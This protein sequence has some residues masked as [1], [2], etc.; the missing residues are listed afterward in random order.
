MKAR[1]ESTFENTRDESL[2]VNNVVVV[3]VKGAQECFAAFGLLF[4]EV[5]NRVE[6]DLVQM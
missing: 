1:I 3:L 6:R 5:R 2:G 4:A